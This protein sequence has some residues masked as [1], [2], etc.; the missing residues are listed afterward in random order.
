MSMNYP[1]GAF[2]YYDKENDKT[3]I[4]WSYVDDP[5]LTHFEIEV[6][7]ENLRKWVK[8]DG[9]NGV[10]PKQSKRGSNY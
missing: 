8:A 2:Q 9:R 3:H 5:N 1:L 6:Y 4:Q 10:Y 7:D